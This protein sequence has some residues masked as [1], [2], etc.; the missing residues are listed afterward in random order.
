MTPH[1]TRHRTLDHLAGQ[2]AV[3]TS[4]VPVCQRPLFY[5]AEPRATHSVLIA[6]EAPVLHATIPLA[7]ET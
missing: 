4:T 2:T 3:L 6:R 1:R 5:P 7:V